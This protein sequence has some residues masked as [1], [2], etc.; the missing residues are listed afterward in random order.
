MVNIT[1]GQ[2]NDPERLVFNREINESTF[3]IIIYPNPSDGNVFISID[4]NDINPQVYSIDVIDI[5][6]RIIYPQVWLNSNNSHINLA[7]LNCG[8][9]FTRIYKGKQMVGAIKVMIVK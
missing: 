8:L 9:Y 4:E 2:P 6:G 7:H 5:S 1:P 3:D